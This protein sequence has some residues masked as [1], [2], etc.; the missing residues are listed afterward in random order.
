MKTLIFTVILT[1]AFISVPNTGAPNLESDVQ[2][3]F[4]T[5]EKQIIE[6]KDVTGL[7]SPGIENPKSREK[8]TGVN[9]AR[10]SLVLNG[11]LSS[12]TIPAEK[13]DR[14]FG[15]LLLAYG[16]QKSKTGFSE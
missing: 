9:P 3:K 5:I 14:L 12:Y 13:R 10:R 15:L 8:K 6:K 2:G 4:K 1:I 11:K 7:K 16:S